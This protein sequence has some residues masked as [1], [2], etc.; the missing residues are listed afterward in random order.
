MIA[1]SLVLIALGGRA[2]A[3][4]D[5]GWIAP[6]PDSA[7]PSRVEPIITP[8]LFPVDTPVVRRPLAIEYS[9]A[10]YTRLTIHRV[11]SY[12][13]LPLFAAEYSLGQNL[14]Q[15][16][17]PPTWMRPTHA[18]VAGG[19][20]VLFGVNTITGVW[21]LWDSRKDPEGRTRRIVHSALMLASDA[22][23]AA[24]GATAPGH[25]HNY[26]DY[27]TYQQR[28]NLHRGIALGSIAASTVG[29]VMMW[30]WK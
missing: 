5:T 27:S 30:F 11:G 13:M 17:S 2:V 16:V 9:D 7:A 22:G 29:A 10:Y 15:D 21:N 28:V 26:L 14:I 25:H 24:A 3:P 8:A 23:F 1:I 4:N 18:L 12:A 20:G 6:V 19:I